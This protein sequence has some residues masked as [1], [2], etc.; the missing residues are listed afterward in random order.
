MLSWSRS[1]YSKYLNCS[2]Y[3]NDSSK[4]MVQKHNQKS[5]RQIININSI[6]LIINA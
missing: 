6:D 2:Q 4:E 1:T 5:L 3:I